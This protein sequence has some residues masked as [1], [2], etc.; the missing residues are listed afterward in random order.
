MMLAAHTLGRASGFAA[1]QTVRTPSMVQHVRNLN[2]L[3]IGVTNELK[4]DETRVV[5]TPKNVERLLK[6]GASVHVEKGAGSLAG[7]TDADYAAAGATICD[8]NAAW[9]QDLIVKVNPPSVAE[10]ERVGNR[11]IISVLQPAQNEQVVEKLVANGANA[12]ALDMLLRTLS[13]GQAFDVLSSQANVAG[14]RAVIEAAHTLQ[15]PFAGGMTMAGKYPPARVMVVGA[16]VAGLAA[17]QQAK[18]MNA[19]VVAFDVRAAA[20][21]QVE[22]MGA[23]FLK[24]ESSEDGSGAGG[25]AKEMSPEW[26]EAANKML[27]EEMP[28]TDVV[29]TTALIP[30]RPAPK[31]IHKHMVEA[32]PLGAV[33]C[34][35]AAS[36]GGNIETTVAG[37]TVQVGGVTCI[38]HN[39]WPAQ[40]SAIA[41]TMFGGNVTNLIES[42]DHD[43]KFTIDT[44]NDEAVRSVCVVKGGKRL[45]PYMPA[46]AAAPVAA[47]DVETDAERAE[48]EAAEN[49]L[50]APTLNTA[51]GVTGGIGSALAVGTTTAD[52]KFL[53]LMSTF[54]LAGVCGYKV[55]WGV[56]PA[57]HS[58]LMSVTNA[59]SG[60]TAVGGMMIMG[61]H[62]VPTNSAQFFGASAYFLSTI[63]IF[64]GFLITQR[65]LDMFKRPDDPT[66]YNHL[67]IIPAAAG[68]LGY[69]YLNSKGYPDM[70][71]MT[72]VAG[73][74]AC[75]TSIASLADVKTARFGNAMGIV[76]VSTGVAATFGMLNPSTPVAVQMGLLGAGGAA[77]GVKVAGET[78][79]TE[80]PQLVALF[81]SF[82]GAAAV[83]TCVGTHINEAHHFPEM[84]DAAVHK[85]SIFFGTAIGAI[86]TTGSLVAWGKL[87]E[88][89]DSAA[90]NLPGKDMINIACAG[91]NVPLYLA[92][93]GAESTGAGV[94]ILGATSL[95][96]GGMGLHMTAS[97]GGADMPVVITVLNSYSGWA[98][99]CEGFLL[100]NGLMTSVGA[101]IGFSGGILSY[102]M[103]V[104]M[105]RSLS[106]VILGGYGTS[107]TGSGEALTYSGSHTEIDTAG[108]TEKLVN[109]KKIIITPGYGLAVA[110]A[111]YAVADTVKMLVDD[112]KD[113]KFAIHPV[114]GR[115]PGQLNVL[116]AEAGV[117]YD[118]VEEMDEI[119]HEFEEADVALC[120]GANDTI[121][122]AAE[123]DPNCVIAGMPVIHAWKAKSSIIM[124]RSMGVGYAAVD[125]PV[126]FNDNNDMYLGDA[127]ANMDLLATSLKEHYGK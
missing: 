22:A 45:P 105:N 85:A 95:L 47:E 94:G 98:L 102:I 20:A 83:L 4:G 39:N 48:R 15:R 9:E 91:A 11:S 76:G 117:P 107:S 59:I 62:V 37:K 58:P 113:V 10:A 124:K 43:G 52:P 84:T 79:P 109:A 65:M 18:N 56:A 12:F 123:D 97:I 49:D 68:V 119:N 60:I 8:N 54:S 24:V 31:L 93:T 41:S 70:H 14:Y 34:D 106:N 88:R 21:E 99:A 38:G 111:Q 80:L 7:F 6:R 82:V 35:L 42:M 46:P 67:Y 53:S 126:F 30:G 74:V 87:D 29:I 16:G 57:L 110:K 114:A 50:Y 71:K 121:N 108:V 64:G 86:T 17:I 89:L 81:H 115:M 27:L 90:L 100:D 73:S 55:V 23:K 96:W 28:K 69:G 72:Y 116:L 112:G 77:I 51:L 33:T 5:L 3:S 120:I 36:A 92:Y 32:M 26:F 63:N 75:I 127:K 13:R 19:D 118:I 78:G 104:A 1:R 2:G 25:Y 61:G 122:S 66:E 101:L 40:M 125:N 44:E 103:C